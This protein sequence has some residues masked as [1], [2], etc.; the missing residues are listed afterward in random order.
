MSVSASP[1]GPLTVIDC[2]PSDAF[3]YVTTQLIGQVVEVRCDDGNQ[4][5]G[6]FSLSSY[7]NDNTILLRQVCNLNK[8]DEKPLPRKKITLDSILEINAASATLIPPNVQSN[9]FTDITI[10]QKYK[11]NGE[12]RELVP[13]SFLT[14]G[15]DNKWSMPLDEKSGDMNWDQIGVNE[16]NF[17]VESVYRGEFDRPEMPA[18]LTPEDYRRA[19]QIGREIEKKKTNNRVLAEDRGQSTPAD[20]DEDAKYSRVDTTNTRPPEKPSNWQR[21]KQEKAL[22]KKA[23]AQSLAQNLLKRKQDNVASHNSSSEN[24]IETP[25]TTSPEPSLPSRLTPDIPPESSAAADA[26]DLSKLVRNSKPFVSKKQTQ[27]PV[28]SLPPAVQPQPAYAT[29]TMTPTAAFVPQAYQPQMMMY[30]N[31][32]FYGQGYPQMYAQTYPQT[33]YYPSQYPSMNPQYY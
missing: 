21:L 25:S 30:P 33:P 18:N 24:L 4:Y 20:Y 17:K 16:R 27:Q 31:Q 3:Q 29:H 5:I 12:D 15:N 22:Q 32:Q 26:L 14:S 23:E 2:S 10:S 6:I 28:N 8:H 13:F 7:S 1:P 19:E 9:A 11:Q